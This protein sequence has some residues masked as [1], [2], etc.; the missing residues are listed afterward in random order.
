MSALSIKPVNGESLSLIRKLLVVSG[1]FT[2]RQIVL[3]PVFFCGAGVS[4][5]EALVHTQEWLHPLFLGCWLIPSR[6]EVGGCSSEMQEWRECIF[7][8]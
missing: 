2:G 1:S 5:S 4:Y 6:P 7:I 8:F 3:D